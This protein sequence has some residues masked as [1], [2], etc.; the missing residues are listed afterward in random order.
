MDFDTFSRDIKHLC[1]IQRELVKLKTLLHEQESLTDTFNLLLD[2][3]AQ[4]LEKIVTSPALAH[5]GGVE[6]LRDI[7]LRSTSQ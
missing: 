6:D 1:S 7:L 3:R 2:C 5:H 4:V